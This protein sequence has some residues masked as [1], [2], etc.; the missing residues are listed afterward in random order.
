M[1]KPKENE[2]MANIES[3]QFNPGRVA[4]A[5]PAFYN[6][7]PVLK[8]NRQTVLAGIEH[9]KIGKLTGKKILRQT[10][11]P[12]YDELHEQFLSNFIDRA[13]KID[14]EFRLSTDFDIPNMSKKNGAIKVVDVSPDGSVSTP[15]PT[16]A[17]PKAKSAKAGK[18]APPPPPQSD[19]EKELSSD[20]SS[21]EEEAAVPIRKTKS[22]DAA[23]LAKM[24]QAY[25]LQKRQEEREA[26]AELVL[27]KA[28]AKPRPPPQQAQYQQEMPPPQPRQRAPPPPIPEPEMTASDML[29]LP[30]SG[31]RRNF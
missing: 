5:C 17:L 29:F 22:V 12:L 27:Q 14:P 31:Y 10:L 6:K 23:K 4:N 20:S 16:E 26:I 30:S 9:A 11:M 19:S 13:Q 24:K 18:R 7:N 2:E 15:L 25:K 3:R 8:K 1:E 28:R 21:D